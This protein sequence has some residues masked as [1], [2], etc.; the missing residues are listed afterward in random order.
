MRVSYPVSE[1]DNVKPVSQTVEFDV[2]ED[3]T[4]AE[5]V[6][7]ADRVVVARFDWHAGKPLKPVRTLK[8]PAV[9]VS[10]NGCRSRSR[11]GPS[12]RRW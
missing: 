3:P 1:K 2:T 8:G 6:A 12:P 4:I 9:D 11:P 10:R 7:A 5:L